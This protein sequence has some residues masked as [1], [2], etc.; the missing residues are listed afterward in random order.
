MN[1]ASTTHERIGGEKILYL[2]DDGSVNRGLPVASDAVRYG[3]TPRPL[4]RIPAYTVLMK[5]P[6]SS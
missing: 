3:S 4:R 5:I 6:L 1:P 2:M